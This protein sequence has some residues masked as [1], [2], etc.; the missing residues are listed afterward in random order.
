[1]PTDS[2]IPNTPPPDPPTWQT[3]STQV[4]FQ[5]RW[6]TVLQDE[7]A[8]PTTE[9]YQYTRLH[10][11]GIGVGVLGFDA[12][13]DHVLL[14]REYRHGVGEVIW[15]CPGGLAQPNEDLRTAGLR[16]LLEETGYAPATLADDSVRYLGVIWDNP[17][18]GTACSHVYAAWG[19]RQVQPPQR[20]PGEFV[21]CRWQSTDWLRAA[22]R[23]GEIRDRVVVGAVA[24]LLLNNLL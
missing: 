12:T 9:S 10:V 3:L 1:M 19:L 8:L 23:N 6:V 16:E 20:D 22:V 24:F 13:G 4:A 7:V 2:Q 14:E 17:A 5:N 18:L 15:Q 21:T 11:N